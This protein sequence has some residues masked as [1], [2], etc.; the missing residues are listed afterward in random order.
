MRI[1]LYMMLKLVRYYLV[2]ILMLVSFLRSE[3]TH[4]RAGDITV[5]RIGDCGGYKYRIILHIYTRWDRP[6]KF[7]MSKGGTV[8][9]GD[10]SKA[11][12]PD[13]V[14][15]PPIIAYTKDGNVG[16]VTYPIEHVYPGPGVYIISYYEPNRNEGINNINASVETPFYVQTQIVIDPFLGCDNSPQLLVPPIDH[17]CTGVKW[18]HNAGAYDP[19]GDSLS[20]DLYVPKQGAVY[21][22]NGIYIAGIDVN[23]YADP[24]SKKFYSTDYSKA[25]ED[26]NGPPIFKIDPV[27]GTVTWDAPGVAGEFNIAFIIREWRK[28]GGTWVPLGYVERDMQIIIESCKNDRPQLQTP[29]DLCVVAGT[30]ITEFITATDADGGPKGGARGL[31]DSVKIEAFSQVF[32]INPSPATYKPVATWQYLSSPTAKAQI[33]FDW[34]TN[35]LH[36]KEQPYTVTFKATDNGAPP[37]ASFKTWN[38]RVVAPPPMWVSAVLN[39]GQRAAQLTWQNYTCS[40]ASIIQVWRRVD[41]APYTPPPCV[42]GI[43]DSLGYSL[44]ASLPIGT[45]AYTDKSLAVGA[46]YCYRLLAIFPAPVG[47]ESVVSSEI[48]IPPII[49]SGPVITNVT[50]DVTDPLVGQVTVKWRPPFEVSKTQ[51]PLP[52]SYEV[53]RAEGFSGN[54]KLTKVNSGAKIPD[55]V[56]VDNGLN[57]SFTI[58]NYRVK[59]Y[60][61]GGNL[62]DTSAVASTVRL[63]LKP[64]YKQ[65]QLNWAAVVPWSNNSFKYPWH[66]IYRSTNSNSKVLTDLVL[67]DSVNVN[68]RQLIYLD[69]GQYNSKPLDTAQNYCYAV[70]TRGSYGNPKIKAPLNNFSE[71]T[72]AVPNGKGSPPCTPELA[73]TGIDC[74]QFN[75][76]P[77]PGA[78]TTYTNTIRWKKPPSDECKKNV[79][80]YNIYASPQMGGQFIKIAEMVTDTF[81]VHSNLPSFAQCY[82]VTAVDRTGLESDP[83]NQFCFDNCPYYELPN[84]FTPN[85]DGCNDKFSAFSVRQYTVDESGYHFP[86]A[87]DFKRDSTHFV[88]DI[89]PKCARFVT[90]VTFT[91]YNR[92]GREIYNYQSGGEKTIYIDWNGKDNDGRDLDAGTYYYAAVVGFDVVDPKKRNRTIKGWVQIVR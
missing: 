49:A 28:I 3:A 82:Q 8:N 34:L 6:V 30:K 91:V 79:R 68:Q 54:I 45:T 16:E 74:S 88:N 83:S 21:D 61:N 44:I 75:Q 7:S 40:N 78:T 36:V 12:H 13:Q 62:I 15:N 42:T 14:D 70:M 60:D 55:T 19:D 85:G 26:G 56:F 92:W 50:I 20:Y 43:P 22:A 65:V 37:L 4:L 39:P 27:T 17:G 1:N 53:Y 5:E 24:N 29:A 66:R 81:Y 72:C 48:C 33:E 86:C 18:T 64:S 76:C 59:A 25:N 51:F 46:K 89:S 10:G 77:T 58:Y 84:V 71:I 63:D 90:A 47:G 32:T 87:G 2:G 41:S 67:I 57:T 52:Y 9:F 23:G 11:F 80:G 69:S 31:G 38:I 73:I 35:C